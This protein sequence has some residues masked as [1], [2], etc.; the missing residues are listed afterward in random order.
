MEIPVI[1]AE[2][3]GAIYERNAI[4]AALPIMT[5]NPDQFKQLQIQNGNEIMI[6]LENCTLKNLTSGKSMKLNEFSSVQMEIYK[7]GGLLNK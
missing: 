6:N 4:N 1:I 2:S 7:R 5:Y 3:F